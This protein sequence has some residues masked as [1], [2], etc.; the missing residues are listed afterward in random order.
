M[1]SKILTSLLL[2]SLVQNSWG[3]SCGNIAEGTVVRLDGEN[4]TL[5]N[6]TVQ[7]QDGLGVCYANTSSLMLKSILPNSPDISYLNLAIA[8]G[9]KVTGNNS[10]GSAF[11]ANGEMLITG[12]HICATINAAKDMGGVCNRSDVPLETTVFNSGQGISLDH[13]QIQKEI[14]TKVSN[15]YDSVN[16]AFGSQVRP[17]GNDSTVKAQSATFIDV[18]PVVPEIAVDLG[19]SVGSFFSEIGKT[20]KNFFNAIFDRNAVPINS[21]V[22]TNFNSEIPPRIKDD[23]GLQNLVDNLEKEN[24]TL[25]PI[26]DPII[27]PI[28][29]DPMALTNEEV[30]NLKPDEPTSPLFTK[31]KFEALR[32]KR[33]LNDKER[34]QLALYDLLQQRMPEYSKHNCEK[35][36]IKNSEKV[37]KQLAAF[38]HQRSESKQSSY[39]EDRLKRQLFSTYL[40]HNQGPNETY[41][42]PINQ[43]VRE[44]LESVYLK[45]LNSY[46]APVSGKAALIN[47]LKTLGPTGLNDNDYAKIIDNLDPQVTSLLEDDYDRYAKKDYSKCSQDRAAYFKNADGLMKDFV[48]HPC[49]SQYVKMGEGIQTL[50]TGLDKSNLLNFEKLT[51]FLLNSP[52]VNYEKALSSLLSPTCDDKSKIRIPQNL[53]CKDTHVYFAPDEIEKTAKIEQKVKEEQRKMFS[54]VSSSLKKGTA[55]GASLCTIFF[56]ENPNHFYNASKKCVV[57]RNDAHHA[58]GII[59]YRCKAGKID[60]LVQNSWGDWRDLNP[61]HE[62]DQKMGKAWINEE[63]MVKNTYMY[64]TL[65]N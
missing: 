9:E 39:Q 50:V 14:L 62:R 45:N 36:D 24:R 44:K 29:V 15:Y 32:K 49:L 60:Y 10:R 22:D 19:K 57:E 46:P 43:D 55:I 25:P 13:G 1:N 58:V 51:D 7:D 21:N 4:G 2:L 48:S 47:T 53:S 5:Q 23:V 11:T 3:Q 12:G 8:H 42:F 28:P 54:Q 6:A 16:K 59:G 52:D 26:V 65:E 64:T 40:I 37:L 17:V 41:E 31:E 35:L 56:K 63:S 20:F 38:L 61:A 30:M 18:K 34:Y 33:T 27:D